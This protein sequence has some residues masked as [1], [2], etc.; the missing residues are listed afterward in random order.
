MLFWAYLAIPVQYLWIDMG[1]YGMFI[2]FIPVYV[3]LLLPMRMVLIG[4]TRASCAP[5]ARSTG[6]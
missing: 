6:A 3:F 4:E 5:P 2:V 1:W